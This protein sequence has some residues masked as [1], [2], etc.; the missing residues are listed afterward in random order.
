MAATTFAETA[1][2]FIADNSA[3]NKQL[4]QIE[5]DVADAAGRMVS[6]VKTAVLSL[7]AAAAAAT[8]TIAALTKLS[9]DA[10]DQLA[11]MSQRVAV[12]VETLSGYKLAADLAGISLEDLGTALQ[13]ASKNI[14]DAA[15][16]T[17]TAGKALES[18]GISAT[19][20][21]G[22]L[23]TVE[24][25]MLEVADR[26][27]IMEDG[28]QKTALA[29]EIFGRSGAALIP[30]LNQGSAAIAAQRK[31]ADLLGTTWTTAQAKQA[32]AFND[33]L[34]RIE[35]ALGGF[36]NAVAGYLMPFVN[37]FLEAAIAKIKEWAASGD[38]KIW[39]LSTAEVIVGAFVQAANAVAAVARA[40]PVILD[41]FRAVMAGLETMRA[42][43]DALIGY[44]LQGLQVMVTAAAAVANTLHL[45]GAASLNESK[46]ILADWIASWKAASQKAADSA[47]GWGDAI[48]TSNA[49]AEKFASTLE[50]QAKQFQDWAGKAMM[51]GTQAAAGIDA[52]GAAAKK[53]AEDVKSVME[54]QVNGVTKYMTVWSK[55]AAWSPP[56]PG[57]AG[58]TA[59]GGAGTA[60]VAPAPSAPIDIDLLKFLAQG[61]PAEQAL[62]QQLKPVYVREQA[63]ASLG[64]GGETGPLA[65][66]VEGLGER[67]AP[68]MDTAYTAL[69]T[70]L[71]KMEERVKSSG[72]KIS[73]TFYNNLEEWFV[74]K[75]TDQAARS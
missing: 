55:A 9:A 25:V 40:A 14:L 28:A 27:A 19:D 66:P 75:L 38:L 54:Y 71:S 74:R 49:A 65:S 11:K 44:L 7:S 68:I 21:T 50:T 5:K 69:D 35:S 62:F 17:G 15:S 61:G 26:F 43:L 4:G 3:L 16:G 64:P 59:A 6:A 33:N 53:T 8:V 52:T 63:L 29:I 30:F 67:T 18:L 32:E 1:I 42:G 31:E 23:K 51:V 24:Q 10:G 36:R 41:S 48:G 45:G 12:S 2:R 22:K 57:A 70:G 37:E 20:Q 39:A 13:R 72:D 56:L 60:G 73:T 47:M 58:Q 34:K 46:A